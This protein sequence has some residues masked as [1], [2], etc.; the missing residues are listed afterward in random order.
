MATQRAVL[1]RPVRGT[2]EGED[3]HPEGSLEVPPTLGR[4]MQPVHRSPV[5][6]SVLMQFLGANSLWTRSLCSSQGLTPF[7][8]REAREASRAARNCTQVS[9]QLASLWVWAL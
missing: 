5:A 4:S 2:V 3:Q 6:Y 1:R 8:R 9:G 7:L